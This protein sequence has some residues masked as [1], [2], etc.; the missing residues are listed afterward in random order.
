MAICRHALMLNMDWLPIHRTL[1]SCIIFRTRSDVHDNFVRRPF[2]SSWLF[3]FSPFFPFPFNLVIPPFNSSID[4]NLVSVQP[5]DSPCHDPNY[6]SAACAVVQAN[7]HASV[8]RSAQPGICHCILAFQEAT[9]I[10]RLMTSQVLFNGRTGKRGQN[11]T[12]NATPSL[13]SQHLADR[14]GYHSTPRK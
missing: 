8:Y 2:S 1:A 10:L 7:L 11:R 6:D 12:N 5:I 9:S 4:E 14:V 13:L 3:S